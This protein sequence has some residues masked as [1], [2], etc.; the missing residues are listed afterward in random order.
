MTQ[1]LFSE[2]QLKQLQKL[3]LP[4]YERLDRIEARLD[5]LES[6]IDSLEGRMNSLEDRMDALEAQFALMVERM[7]DLAQQVANNSHV[8]NHHQEQI[9]NISGLLTQILR[10]LADHDVQLEGFLRRFEEL[11]SRDDFFNFMDT[12]AKR[13]SL[14]TEERA[15]LKKQLMRLYKKLNI[16]YA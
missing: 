9:K 16:E 12:V 14:D 3:L 13:W 15:H 2:G 5:S 7:N 11:P 6:R 8:L 10:K 1:I 4:I